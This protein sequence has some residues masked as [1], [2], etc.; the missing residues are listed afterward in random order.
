MIIVIEY[1][2]SKGDDMGDLVPKKQL[3]KQGSTGVI[4]VATGVALLVV[5]GFTWLPSLII[6][7]I[8]AGVG[9]VMSKDKDDRTAGMIMTG[10]GLLTVATV[11]PFIGGLAGFL[12]TVSGIGLLAAGGLNIFKFIKGWRKRNKQVK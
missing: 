4:A 1:L 6:G 5:N 12:L 8:V 10:A 9:L 11:V 3:V 2:I 7:G